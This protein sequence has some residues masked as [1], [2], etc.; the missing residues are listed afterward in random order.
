MEIPPIMAR[1][2]TVVSLLSAMLAGPAI[3]DEIFSLKFGFA[4]IEPKGTFA[5]DD[6]VTSTKID[7][8]NDL[9]FDGSS[10]LVAEIALQGG[11]FWLSG[12][13]LP[14]KFASSGTASRDIAFRGKIF[15]VGAD[16]RSDVE[17]DVF[18]IGIAYH[19]LDFDHGPARWQLGPEV[20]VK[21]ADIEILVEEISGI[22]SESLTTTELVPTIGIR[23][24]GSMG[25][26]FSVVGRI[27]YFEFRED[28][29]FDA[30]VQ[31]EYS[32]VPMLGIFAGYRYIEVEVNDSDV[33]LDSTFAGPYAGVVAR[34]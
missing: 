7:F 10:G 5:G 30:E 13:Y 34:F 1:I 32:P 29:C 18:D 28:S 15:A 33:I 24:R 16:V 6:G 4:Y 31:I 3:A 20:V 12:T 19:V 2:L 11:R 17:I 27:G 23:V 9:D 14:L 21:I 25:D 26:L 8:E 22:D